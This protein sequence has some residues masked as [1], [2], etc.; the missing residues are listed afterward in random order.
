MTWQTKTLAIFI[1]ATVPVEKAGDVNPL[2][3]VAQNIG[4]PAENDGEQ[5]TTAARQN[6]SVNAWEHPEL[7][8]NG[9][10]SF[11]RFMASFGSPARWAGRG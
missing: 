1:A 11:E 2:L 8:D 4:E 10:A 5:K 3:E 6:K 9:D 7:V